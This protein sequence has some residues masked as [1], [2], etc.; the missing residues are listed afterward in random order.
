MAMKKNMKFTREPLFAV[1]DR[2]KH[3]VYGEGVITKIDTSDHPDYSF[4]Y[5]ADFTGKKG[6]GTKVW[7]PKAKTEKEARLLSRDG[8]PW[9]NTP[10]CEGTGSDCP[11]T[12]FGADCPLCEK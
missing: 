10:Y 5:D 11:A 7:L 8:K 9:D 3:P 2:I 1:G 12:C 4:F 6:D